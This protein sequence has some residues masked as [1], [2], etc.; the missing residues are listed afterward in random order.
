MENA[1][2]TADSMKGRGYG[3]PGRT[4]FSIFEFDKRDKIALV[5][6]LFL[7]VYIFIGNLM[8]EMTF[9]FFPIV[10]MAD[11]SLYVISVFTAYLLLCIYPVTIE[12]WEVRKWNALKSKI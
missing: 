1:I 12:L 5:W 10:K 6:I 4:A 8:G 11:V 2:D 7:G 9:N 3:I